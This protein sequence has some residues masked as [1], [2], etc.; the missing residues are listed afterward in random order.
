MFPTAQLGL[1]DS[2]TLEAYVFSG[3]HRTAIIINGEMQVRAGGNTGR[4]HIADELAL[5]DK[6]AGLDDVIRHM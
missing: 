4:T 2:V 5:L 6:I 1:W 3:V